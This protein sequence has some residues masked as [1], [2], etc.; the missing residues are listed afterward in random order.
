MRGV[1]HL[2]CDANRKEVNMSSAFENSMSDS[3]AENYTQTYPVIPY[4]FAQELARIA[5]IG[6][7]A[8]W[9]CGAELP[10][11]GTKC[12]VCGIDQIQF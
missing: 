4:W 2:A 8:C 5:L 7:P 11:T 3:Q 10:K 1:T 6:D 12:T 9:K